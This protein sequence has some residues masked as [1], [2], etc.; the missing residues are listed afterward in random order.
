MSNTFQEIEKSNKPWWGKAETIAIERIPP[1]RTSGYFP[2]YQE[3]ALRLETTPPH[4]ALRVPIDDPKLL[5]AAHTSLKKMFRR[6]MPSV[7]ILKRNGA[8]FIYQAEQQRRRAGR[9]P[10][11]NGHSEEDFEGLPVE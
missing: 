10:R 5:D 2:L 6:V 9:P 8:L 1:A 4:L 3:L 11:D 7:V